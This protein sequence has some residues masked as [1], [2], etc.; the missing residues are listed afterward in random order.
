MI[1]RPP[2]HIAVVGALLLACC[3]ARQRL[4]VTAG[5]DSAASR[6]AA[7]D[8]S[9]GLE[10]P[11]D[12]EPRFA[13]FPISALEPVW[14]RETE[15]PRIEYD[16]RY[17]DHTPTDLRTMLTAKQAEVESLIEVSHDMPAVIPTFAFGDPERGTSDETLAQPRGRVLNGFRVL[18]ADAVRL[19]EDGD[20]AEAFRRLG[21]AARIAL[22]FARQAD[23]YHSLMGMANGALVLYETV[24]IVNDGL[25]GTPR[26]DDVAAILA[27]C[28]HLRDHAPVEAAKLDRAI[29]DVEA[30]L[31]PPS[32]PSG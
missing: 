10:T 24:P 2:A 6:S 8:D 17:S 21:A 13:H 9:F 16:A 30:A 15:V 5:E 7:A 20:D 31:R 23:E 11:D 12:W 1:P 32:P 26:P 3:G 18:R 14:M 22:A 29:A 25:H 28:E 27:V 4:S 19:H